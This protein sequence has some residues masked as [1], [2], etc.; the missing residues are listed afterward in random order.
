MKRNVY[1]SN[2]D[3]PLGYHLAQ[4]YRD[5]HLQFHP[6]TRIIGS[7]SQLTHLNGV[8]AVINVFRFISSLKN[9]PNSPVEPSWTAISSSSTLAHQPMRQRSSS[10]VHLSPFSPQRNNLTHLKTTQSHRYLITINL[11]RAESVLYRAIG[12]REGQEPCQDSR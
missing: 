6:H 5:D 9:S 1:I 11:G 12:H 10:N 8:Y 2:I 7:A 4:F 3:S